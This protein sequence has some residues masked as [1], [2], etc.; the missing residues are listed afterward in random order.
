MSISYNYL[1]ICT[2][3]T[4]I[5]FVIHTIMT[6][7][8]VQLYLYLFLGKLTITQAV[9]LSK[10]VGDMY[11]YMSISSWLYLHLYGWLYYLY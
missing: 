4:T 1:C 2:K 5:I 8:Y 7:G 11:V 10:K 9:I 3:D 6:S